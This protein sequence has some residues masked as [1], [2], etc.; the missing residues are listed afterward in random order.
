MPQSKNLSPLVVSQSFQRLMQVD[1][2]DN[3]T[4]LDGTGSVPTLYSQGDFTGSNLYV[5]QSLTLNSLPNTGSIR[6]GQLFLSG[7]DLF[8]RVS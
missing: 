4:I 7:S 2:E 3:S 8:F 5:S 1:P 6:I